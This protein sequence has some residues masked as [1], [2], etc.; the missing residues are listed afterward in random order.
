MFLLRLKKRVPGFVLTFFVGS[1]IIMSV[2]HSIGT[3]FSDAMLLLMV[4]LF[5]V[6]L[7]A[8]LYSRI[9]I[10]VSLSTAILTLAVITIV[11]S[12]RK[13]FFSSLAQVPDFFR[14][15][16]EFSSGLTG[17]NNIYGV[18]LLLC[19]IAVSVTFTYI[20]TEIRFYFPLILAGGM[21]FF[22]VQWLYDY[23]HSNAY[24][25]MF[26]SAL[27]VYY[28][29]HIY[30]RYYSQSDSPVLNR[31]SFF[32]WACAF[33]V[34]VFLISLMLPHYSTPIKWDWMDRKIF[35]LED[36]WNDLGLN[37]EAFEYFSL[38]EA[39]FGNSSGMLGGKVSLDDTHVLTV[40]SERPV[41]LKGNCPA[42]YENNRW[43]TN[44]PVVTGNN[45]R[46]Y[47][48]DKFEFINGLSFLQN[49][50]N[51]STG[52]F[53]NQSVHVRF[54]RLKT[55]TVFI[56]PR[57]G[58]IDLG[59]FE[60]TL[61]TSHH[62]LL[63]TENMLSKGFSYDME[64]IAVDYDSK[65][66]KNLLKNSRKGLYMD[67]LNQEYP[68]CNSVPCLIYIQPDDGTVITSKEL[69]LTYDKSDERF[70]TRMTSDSSEF[71]YADNEPAILMHLAA[72]AE[73][74]YE[75]YLQTPPGFPRRISYLAH[76]IT[77]K[78]NNNYEK[79]KALERYLS[80]NYS[81]TLEPGKIPAGRD[82]VDY[83]LFDG[84]EG[85]CTY[86]ATA[87]TMMARTLGI[88]AR[89]VEGYVLP[90][91]PYNDKSD[92]YRVTNNQ[93]HAWTEVYLEGAGWVPFEPTSP[94]ISAFYGNRIIDPS[95]S[96]GFLNNPE[97]YDY[98]Q[99][100]EMYDNQMFSDYTSNTESESN[101]LSP[102]IIILLLP[103]SLTALVASA[104]LVNAVRIKIQSIILKK[105]AP[106]TAVI[107]MFSI[108]LKLL[109]FSGYPINPGETV[110]A[111]AD[112][113]DKY[114]ILPPRNR[115]KISDLFDIFLKARYSNHSVTPQMRDKALS[116]MQHFIDDAKSSGK[117]K[118][119]ISRY[120]KGSV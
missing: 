65:S 108:Y 48:W 58:L 16:Y 103:G 18:G 25:Y 14:W 20:F 119:F 8:I 37:H 66:I 35:K 12:F 76:S 57:L 36:Y 68:G 13:A 38:N 118:Y 72:R 112:R 88:P 43:H 54:E 40:K 91:Q 5:V 11:P 49:N 42:F 21:T 95:F 80:E 27:L 34:T 104:A 87:M 28:L 110:S 51:M 10:I 67:I 4:L 7:N 23:L 62:E 120:I 22:I 60:I 1:S 71:D 114:I 117:F 44:D 90:A 97:Y 82:F 9:S 111:F 2:S 89:Y 55:K 105:C 69:T 92:M 75:M 33:S 29:F 107:H 15:V 93:A 101:A 47:S 109:A 30:N 63:S 41:Y 98:L 17:Y 77:D 99:D 85:Y 83:F 94:F 115:N 26:L 19:I 3:G 52:F 86:F 96:S 24:F 32:L 56:P 116:F 84:K 61:K 78:F 70:V 45:N 106:R 6:V 73:R 50:D 64:Y 59:R 31:N 79:I 102:L 100:L 113:L 81:Y 74:H 39:G 53:K 46:H